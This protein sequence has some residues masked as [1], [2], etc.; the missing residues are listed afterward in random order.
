MI[1]LVLAQRDRQS[2]ELRKDDGSIDLANNCQAADVVRDDER[3]TPPMPKVTIDGKEL[4]VH[5][6]VTILDAALDN[7][8][9]LTHN[10]GGNCACSTCHVI[11]ESG[12]ENLSA[13]RDDEDD[14]L[15]TAF[16]RTDRSRLACQAQVMGDIKVKTP[17][18]L[19]I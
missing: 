19:E 9:E 3:K 1:G 6:G 4:D 17:P 14:M 5:P 18:K 11:I 2:P 15:D 12:A 16:R 8:I 13:M 7:G 10:C